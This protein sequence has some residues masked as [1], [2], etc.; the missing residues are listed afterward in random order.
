MEG[1]AII[2]ER[3]PATLME[4]YLGKG[5]NFYI[6]YFYTLLRWGNYLVEN[7]TNVTGSIRESRK[8]VPLELKNT[9]RQKREAAFCQHDNIVM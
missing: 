2:T 4:R 8:Q 7:G 1:G 6:E 5:Q 9:I 3:I